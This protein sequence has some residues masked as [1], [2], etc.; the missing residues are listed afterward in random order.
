MACFCPGRHLDMSILST[1]VSC[2]IHVGFIRA[3]VR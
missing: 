3:D 1:V 2:F